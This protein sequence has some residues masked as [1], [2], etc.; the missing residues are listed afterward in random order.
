MIDL[1]N[2][3]RGLIFDCDGTLV[4]TMPLHRRLWD[5]LMAEEGV[6]LPPGFIDSHTG[7]PTT[8]IVE[9]I[10]REQSL[11]IDPREFRER[12]ESR[13][14]ASQEPLDPI[15]PVVETAR[16]H[17]EKLPMAVVSG[18]CLSNVEH[19]LRSIG[20]WEWFP[21]VLTADDPIAPKPAPDLFLEAARRIGVPADACH[22]FEDGDTGIVAAKA[23][24]MSVTDVR[25]L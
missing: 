14:R 9:I 13:F 8:V 23:A 22:V 10:N 24:G 17:R 16:R 12:K 21:E 19:S 1:P 6:E 15:E 7:R 5:E 18:G 25:E 2:H 20:V 4:D 11:S 3:V